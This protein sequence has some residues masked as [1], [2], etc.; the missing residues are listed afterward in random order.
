[1]ANYPQKTNI[2][3][4][5]EGFSNFRLRDRHQTTTNFMDL[6]VAFCRELPPNSAIKDLNMRSFARLDTM[7]A[8]TQGD[9]IVNSRAYFVPY[10]TICPYFTDMRNDV[11]HVF[12][13]GFVAIPSLVPTAYNREFVDSFIKDWT[14]YDFI[15]NVQLEITSEE[16]ENFDI[17]TVTNDVINN[18]PV[19]T[20]YVL[21]AKGARI[22]KLLMQIGY[23]FDFNNLNSI[24]IEHSLLP[25]FSLLK[26]YIDHYYPSQYAQSEEFFEI[27]KWLQY[28]KYEVPMREYINY[29]HLRYMYDFID[30][31]C[32]SN[33][34]FVS[35]W[36]NPVAPVNGGFSPVT[37]R[38]ITDDNAQ[39]ISTADNGTP[40]HGW[41]YNLTQFADTA[42]HKLSDFMR[43][44]QI[45]GSRAL[46]RMLARF[47]VVLTPAKLNRSVYV[48]DF[49]QNILF[50]DVTST[51][52][53]EGANL[54][55][56]AGKGILPERTAS[57]SYETDEDGLFMILTSVVPYTGYY[58]GADR[59]TRHY[60]ALDFLTPEFDGLATQGLAISELYMP[61]QANKQY[62][63]NMPTS[64][65]VVPFSYKDGIFGYTGR[66]A[67]Y[68][69]PKDRLTG[70]YRLGSKNTS[71]EAWH[72]FRDIDYFAKDLAIADLK[73]D[74]N[75]IRGI[76][77]SQYNRIFNYMADDTDKIKI[78][79]Y[80]D[81]NLRLPAKPLYDTYEFSNEDKSKMVSV[82]VGGA[83]A[84]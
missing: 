45:V 51:A 48:S 41:A 5:I 68:K 74:I 33:D 9:A 7:R 28:N 69:I 84:N 72:L 81:Y 36:D 57:F 12:D 29:E 65:N 64:G 2:P 10:R 77:S 56:Y 58:Q 11:P 8:P 18:G 4:A 59:H 55:S 38:D 73:H 67:E 24:S 3:I 79:H 23:G 26:V 19:L 63:G 27:T 32:Y 1:M 49:E 62:S 6:G 20:G 83:K 43:R 70:D 17:V 76:D 71:L 50:G 31:V 35:A 39:S 15:S 82:D 78:S 61:M 13:D 22:M 80:F 25:L 44:N 53:T 14:E 66:Y 46:D 47:G 34:Y 42:L 16:A 40:K 54:G 75:F 21:S 30:K 60:T 52:D 37:I